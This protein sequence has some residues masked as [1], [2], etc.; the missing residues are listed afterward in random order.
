MLEQIKNVFLRSA[1]MQSLIQALAHQRVVPVAGTNP[2][3]Q[4]FVADLLAEP[5]RT[6]LCVFS[7]A[8]EANQ[9]Y[10]DMQEIAADCAVLLFPF[11][12]KQAWSELGPS[13]ENIGRK[14]CVLKTLAQPSQAMVVTCAA[15]LLEKVAAPDQLR[16]RQIL[17]QQGEEQSFDDLIESLVT[18]GYSREQRVEQPGEIS[19]RGGLVDIFCYEELNP[20]RIEF[21]GDTIESIREFDVESQRSLTSRSALLVLPPGA[22]GLCGPAFDHR[23]DSLRLTSTLLDYLPE[24]SLVLLFE[25][26]LITA[27]LADVEQD[28]QVRS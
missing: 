14:L 21:F 6:L 16:R 11:H 4:A 13:N 10:A 23:V 3:S 24:A 7:Q 18:M 15:A 5:K 20:C 8:E 28:L 2:A 17:L 27:T 25:P 19:V 12:D 9:F 22:G 26:E 1:A